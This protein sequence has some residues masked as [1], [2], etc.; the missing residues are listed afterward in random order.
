[1]LI[2]CG[3]LTRDQTDEK[4]YVVMF[5]AS[6]HL[7]QGKGRRWYGLAYAASSMLGDLAS[8]WVTIL[9]ADMEPT[10][11]CLGR[12]ISLPFLHC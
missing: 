10:V 4:I 3:P 12:F 6:A 11:L 2:S 1:M 9:A 8:S 5:Y 7:D